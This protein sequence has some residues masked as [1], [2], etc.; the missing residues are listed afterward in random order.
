[1]PRNN[2]KHILLPAILLVYVAI[3][4]IVSYPRYKE[5][6]E[7]NEYYAVIGVSLLLA[8]LLFFILKRRKKIREQFNKKS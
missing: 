1:M 4:A 8:V 7:W 3:L 6:G 5:S 2:K